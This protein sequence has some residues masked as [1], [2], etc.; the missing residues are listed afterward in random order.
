MFLPQTGHHPPSAKVLKGVGAG[1]VELVGDFDGDTFR[2]VYTV[3]FETAIYVL[4]CFKKESKRGRQT[5]KTDLDLTRRRA[6]VAEADYKSRI[7]EDPKG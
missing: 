1:V 4:H 5:Q 3:N 2:S 7:K 6:Q